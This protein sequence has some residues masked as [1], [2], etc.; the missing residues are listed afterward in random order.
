MRPT[1]LMK[2]SE[3][4]GFRKMEANFEV[5]ADSLTADGQF[6][7]YAS[8]FNIVDQGGDAVQPG[9]FIEGIISAKSEGRLIPMLWQHDRAEPLGTW[10]DMAEDAKGLYVKGQFVLEDNPPAK[11]A[12]SLLKAKAIGGMSIGYRIP[13]AGAEEDPKRRGVYLLKKL[14]LVEVSL[15]TMP[16]LI[17]AK[18]TAVKNMI[19]RGCIPSVKEFAAS[20]I[21][22]G[23]ERDLAEG[24]A[25]KAAPLLRSEPVSEDAGVKSF[26]D[27]LAAGMNDF[28]L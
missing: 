18:V 14:N 4:L 3:D 19:E 11:R 12:L 23:F 16:M 22:M 21:E 10:I 6:E 17:Q 25:S 27:A 1:W 5:K 13:A 2:D 7:G 15:V 8:V 28:A 24:I 26:V 9:A 20:L